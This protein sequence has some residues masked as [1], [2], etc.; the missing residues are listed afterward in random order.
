MRLPNQWISSTLKV[1]SIVVLTALSLELRLSL[2]HSGNIAFSI[3]LCQ[4]KL[5]YFQT[6]ALLRWV[7]FKGMAGV[8]AAESYFGDKK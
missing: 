6:K 2:L 8:E 3:A 7:S 1:I 4:L 5:T